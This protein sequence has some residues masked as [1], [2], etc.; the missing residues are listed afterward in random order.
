MSEIE[1]AIQHFSDLVN[2]NPDNAEAVMNLAWTFE[3]QGDYDAAIAQF[4]SALQID[5]S[6]HHALYGLGLTLLGHG[7]L[8]GAADV[9][10]RTESL[11]DGVENKSVL[12]VMARQISALRYR[13]SQM[14][15]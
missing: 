5:P 4:E 6:N 15:N 10:A 14:A 3:R 11:L 12:V 8:D 13:M 1:Q 9:L 7:D 2:Q